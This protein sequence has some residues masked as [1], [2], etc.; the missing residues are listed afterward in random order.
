MIEDQKDI[1]IQISAGQF[2][3]LLDAMAIARWVVCAGDEFDDHQYREDIDSLEQ[4]LFQE[5]IRLGFSEQVHK[6]E[7]DGHLYHSS[8]GEDDSIAWR[9]LQDHEE[10]TFWEELIHRFSSV[11][12]MR[13]VDRN[14][15]EQRSQEENFTRT[16]FH[17]DRIREA[18]RSHGLHG[19]ILISA[20]AAE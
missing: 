6:S 16:C 9:A 18:L 13:E 20:N 3:L 8:F 15:W 10:E 11:L 7:G 17:E 19:L 5:A 1:S 4:K 14:T 12:A 2:R